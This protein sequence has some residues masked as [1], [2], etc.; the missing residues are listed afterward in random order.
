MAG[1]NKRQE[2][3]FI[4][5]L[6]MNT[7]GLGDVLEARAHRFYT[8]EQMAVG[9]RVHDSQSVSALQLVAVMLQ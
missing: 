6:Q 9:G 2:S 1:L 4:P 5:S 8:L 3:F 7:E